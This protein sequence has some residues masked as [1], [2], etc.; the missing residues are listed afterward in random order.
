M[1]VNRTTPDVVKEQ[2]QP[3]RLTFNN[4]MQREEHIRAFC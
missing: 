1:M 4:P 3:K 2:A